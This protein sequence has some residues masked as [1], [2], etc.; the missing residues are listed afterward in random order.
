MLRCKYS[1]MKFCSRNLLI[2][3]RLSNKLLMTLKAN[4]QLTIR[5]KKR[6]KIIHPNRKDKMQAVML[7]VHLKQF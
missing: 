7:W 3:K 1:L 4:G 2:I 5:T 6:K